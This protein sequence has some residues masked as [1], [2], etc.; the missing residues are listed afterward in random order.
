[1]IPRLKWLWTAGAAAFAAP[2]ALALV[3]TGPAQN[4]TPNI[5]YSKVAPRISPS[6][7]LIV[8][9]DYTG[10]V[11]P[12]GTKRD[13][14]YKKRAD[15]GFTRVNWQIEGKDDEWG[16]AA[17]DDKTVVFHSYSQGNGRT[18]IWK[19]DTTTGA[20]TQMTT[21]AAYDAFPAISP[22]GT[23][24]VFL[25]QRNS[26]NYQM[27]L[28]DGSK[29]E[30]ATDN[31]PKQVTQLEATGTSV[32]RMV[33]TSD[34]KSVVFL[35]KTAAM[36]R[37]EVYIADAADVD[38]DGVL[39][40][41]RP[42]TDTAAYKT[43][44]AIGEPAVYGDRIYFT[45]NAALDGTGKNHVYSVDLNGTGVNADIW[46][47]SAS[48]ANENYVSV[49]ADGM[50]VLAG[51]DAARGS[52]A[53]YVDYYPMTAGDNTP[54]GASGLLP[55]SPQG[56]HADYVV[57][58]F[59]GPTKIAET[60]TDN[61]GAWA[62]TGLRPGGYFL[63]FSSLAGHPVPISTVT[64]P[65][66]VPPGGNAVVDVFSSG[67]TARRPG[68]VVPTIQPNGS[69]DI[70][71][72]PAAESALTAGW[73]YVNFN[74]FRGT[75]ANGPWTK[76]GTVAKDGP[77]FDFN[78]ATPGDLTKA[79][80]SVT[81]VTTDGT[82]TLESWYADA[83]QAANNLIFNPS[84]ELVD[85]SGNPIGYSFRQGAGGD[86]TFGTTTTE[87]ILGSRSLVVT[88][89][90]TRTDTFADISV[91]YNIPTPGTAESYVH[92]AYA[93]FIDM[94][95]AAGQTIRQA[96]SFTQ[97]NAGAGTW[98]DGL[99]N[100]AVTNNSSAA[101]PTTP[102]T[103]LYQVNPVTTHN[104]STY[105]RVTLYG[106]TPA[107]GILPNQSRAVYDELRFQVKRVGDTGVVWGRILDAA[108][109]P[110]AGVSVTDG[111]KTV[112]SD[113]NGV[114]AIRDSATGDH[115]VTISYPGQTSITRQIKNIGGYVFS[116]VL[117]FPSVI[118]PTVG[119]RV[120][121]PNGQPAVGAKVSYTVGKISV[122]GS[123]VFYSATTD[124]NGNYTID[125]SGQP[126]DTT[127]TIWVSAHKAGY[128]STYLADKKILAGATGRI[129]F[130]LTLG[131]ATPVIEVGRAT[132]PPTIDGVVNPS[133]WAKSAEITSFLLYPTSGPYSPTTRAYAMWDDG[134]LYVAMVADEPN[135]AGIKADQTGFESAGSP[136]VWGDDNFQIF[137]DPLSALGI[138]YGREAWQF[139][140]NLN[141][142]IGITDGSFRIGPLAQGLD[143]T[144]SVF[145]L[146]ADSTVDAA[147]NRWMAEIAIPF[148]S[149][150]VGGDFVQAPTNGT[151]WMGMV[152]R[153]RS[154]DGT[155][156][157]TSQVGSKFSE[158]DKWNTL[159][160]VNT[161]SPPT[162][163][164]L[165]ALKI[166]GGLQAATSKVGDVNSSGA[167]TLE[168][169]VS[170]LRKEQG[171]N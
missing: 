2:A 82:T 155:N 63:R 164:A 9:T 17:P 103:W 148:T 26:A 23:K 95:V 39:D 60:T 67:F 71:F 22:D 54:G 70:R 87:A 122:D 113:S 144:Q 119:G 7:G 162:I 166:A 35:Y 149:W 4:L 1:M 150:I 169:A 55:M 139:G 18:D 46:Q 151:E 145:D 31:V 142:D 161:V 136:G 81:S 34:S 62:F 123:E 27:F 116:E 133:E 42:V 137:L 74:V 40:N 79:F 68:G 104:P 25:S 165:T 80:Y 43:G 16:V 29:P 8:Y 89:G 92:G 102:A 156:A 84:F 128:K 108:G 129:G 109:T 94:P 99:Y 121:L 127:K 168:D 58:I 160:F 76:I 101:L 86:A 51:T 57:E 115:T 69:V 143:T 131:G 64:R 100:S 53:S 147:N 146:R 15:A 10:S 126:F 118:A 135:T 107:E 96:F 132:T 114:F 112:S 5:T 158:T 153:Y 85:G 52:Y 45:T 152:A 124:A 134:N 91:P 44:T 120:L 30:N 49:G 163:S 13:M 12:S 138:G 11:D 93:R 66:I 61:N 41:L 72:Q 48:N 125:D 73:S 77:F 19:F 78:D 171:L 141:A 159:R 33:F 97:P 170:L 157:S 50:V 88:Q 24:M 32:G 6:G 106:N 90:L 140:M 20:S 21:N 56:S 117:A 36:P 111:Q 37:N 3:P 154:Q 130:D 105:T 28:M 14:Y 47:V 38:N 110:V 75:S 65:V 59:N 167:I 83:G 98:Y